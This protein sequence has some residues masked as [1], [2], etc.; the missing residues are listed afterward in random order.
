MGLDFDAIDYCRTLLRKPAPYKCP[1]DVEKCGK[2]YK[3]IYGL[4]YHLVNFDHD[5]PNGTNTSHHN[6]APGG[7][8]NAPPPH[9]KKGGRGNRGGGAAGSGATANG[10]GGRQS[11]GS[12][13]A[14]AAAQQQS[15]PPKEGLTYSEAQRMVQF[16]IDGR[17]IKTSVAEPIAII[18]AETMAKMI[19]DKECAPF[20]AK[21]V[22]EAHVKLPEASYRLR[23]D[24]N[25]CDAPPRPNAYIRFIEKS[26]EE[27]DGE[28]EYDVDE[29][30]TTWLG[31]MNER[32]SEQGLAAV[33]V[34][35]LELLMDRLEK[36]SYFQAAA[37]GQSG[38]EVDDDA[39]CCIC[40]DGE[41][42]NTNVILFCDMCN[43]AVHQDCY[44]VP[45]IPEGQWLCRRC[46]QS[47][48][49]PVDCVLCP[50][51]GG[52]FKQTDHNQW[53]HVV[54][55]LWIPEVRFANTVFLE[56]IDSI[57]NIPAARWRLTCYICKQRGV[58]ACIQ[59]QRNSC[60][61]AFH[62]TCAQQAGLHMR[63]DTVRDDRAACAGQ[64]IVVQKTA[65][66]DA[67]CPA[68]KGADGSVVATA[69]DP[70]AAVLDGEQMRKKSRMKMKL[71]R[72]TL[73]KKRTSVPLILI[74]T[75]PPDRL[76]EIGN[77]ISVP[78]KTA[79]IQRLIAYWT[80]K[81]QYRNGVPL[82]R[83]LQSQSSQGARGIE[84]SP[85]AK[86]LQQQLKYWQCLR[87]DLERARLL[88]E[89]V[90]KREKLKAAYIRTKESVVMM[91]LN[92]L[93]ATMGK[94]L[95][96]IAA[97]DTADIFGEP[98]DVSEVPDYMDVVTQPMDLS[99][100][101]R[102][103]ES[104][105]Y[106]SLD[107]MQSDFDLM[108]RNCLA[109]NNKETVFY[110]AG[111]RMRD[112]CGALFRAARSELEAEGVGE[113]PKTDDALAREIDDEFRDLLKMNASDVLLE[114]LQL[115]LEKAMRLRLGLVRA[116]R[117]KH[118]RIEM[119]KVK[120]VLNKAAASA[121]RRETGAM[122]DSSQSDAEGNVSG[123]Q[124]LGADGPDA[125]LAEGMALKVLVGGAVGE[126]NGTPPCSPMKGLN[127]SASPSGV[128]RRY[129]DLNRIEM[130]V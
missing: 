45:Y 109:Y 4:Q 65:Y 129:N 33:S 17:S 54:C 1:V 105:I 130:F 92:P 44:G 75:I 22:V 66:C 71:A 39:V 117:T 58:G 10:G 113:T 68:V 2:S 78:K 97:R 38:A 47:P 106:Y 123:V 40:V 119:T 94:L 82:L 124:P 51:T 8:A 12:G 27:L 28:V 18:K 52:A 108:I 6:S 53:A 74:P 46:L 81:R 107:H 30:D 56:P 26:A 101:R 7:G 87:Q 103:L 21:V 37:N 13:A 57:E 115:L 91:E 79:F 42:Q 111:V 11:H 55:A 15:S 95:Q 76:S 93:E 102:K 61:A 20:V 99:T 23:E 83:R 41:C 104:G 116:K 120:K 49:R 62:V 32:R 59:C 48:S 125:E 3:S 127:S 122:S 70:S 128:N 14:N 114:R 5:H 84:G 96:A 112:Q 24:Y 85:N 86:E 35:T 64:P 98:V 29:E 121:G 34:D 16:D 72:E 50:N 19:E 43:L 89:L 36:E 31:I 80:L 110:R 67:H 25:I 9:R 69:A 60:Y 118:I 73:A 63:M 77:M 88:C 126:A 100:M 90:R